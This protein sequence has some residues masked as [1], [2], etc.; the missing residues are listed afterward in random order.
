MDKLNFLDEELKGLK[1]N[2]LYREFRTVT[3]SQ[4]PVVEVDGRQVLCLCSNNYLGLADRRELR[5]AAI[6]AVQRYGVGA[7]A[8]RLVSGQMKLHQELEE[9][10]A[11]FENTEAA[12]VFPTGYMANLGTIRALV[13]KEDLVLGDRLNHAS[14]LDACRL[15]EA[16]F[17]VYAHGDLH[18]LEQILQR[19]KSFRRKLIVTD[20][21][22][23]MDGDLAPLR[24]IVE[25][26]DRYGALVMI[27]EAH[28]TGVLGEN[29]RGASEALGVE[30]R[31]EV[32]MGTLSKA[33]GCVGGF[34]AGSEKLIQ[35][36][37]NK[38]RTFIYTTALPPAV[39]ASALAALQIVRSE[40]DL[41]DNLKK[42]VSFVRQSLGLSPQPVATPMIPVIV[43]EA[44]PT[45]ELS[46]FLLQAGILAPAIRP[47][48]VPEGTSRLRLSLMATHTSCQ[49][50]QACKAIQQGIEKLG[51]LFSPEKA[52]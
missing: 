27:D 24:E 47:P 52:H 37:R 4:G 35:F 3:G 13:E 42:N 39:C 41:R 48:T 46:Q 51:I 29:G 19:A 20:S 40:P 30:G 7:A 25:L 16:T 9:S 18:A 32:K 26:A 10:L 38:A 22:F 43:G 45:L 12:I 6:E 2:N 50:G 28:G 49:L 33:L 14:L 34:V 15:A 11:R 44:T 8:S 23:S 21:V 1:E 17:R 31:L 36:L 5:E